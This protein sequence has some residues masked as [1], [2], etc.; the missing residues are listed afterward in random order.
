MHMILQAGN[1]MN[2]G[3]ALGNAAGFQLSS[4]K[5]L[6]DTKANKPG[7]TLM[8]YVAMVSRWF[9]RACEFTT[10]NFV[11]QNPQHRLPL[12]NLFYDLE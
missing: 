8:H 11:R 6:S 2:S 10:S 7:I 5:K 1:F 3:V 4:L 12:L 9:E